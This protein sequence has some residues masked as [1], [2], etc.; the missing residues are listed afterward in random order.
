M[1]TKWHFDV[2]FIATRR[3]QTNWGSLANL[4]L[5]WTKEALVY[6]IFIGHCWPPGAV[7]CGGPTVGKA[8]AYSAQPHGWNSQPCYGSSH[9]FH[10]QPAYK[11]IDRLTSWPAIHWAS[12]TVPLHPNPPLLQPAHDWGIWALV[13]RSSRAGASQSNHLPALT[14]PASPRP[15]HVMTDI[16]IA[17]ITIVA[18]T[19]AWNLIPFH[20]GHLAWELIDIHVS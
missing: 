19:S 8:A 11:A 6:T 13:S 12:L 3:P 14:R 18:E 10:I 1:F 2:C 7:D 17:V 20:S 5:H 4:H 9:Y 16:S 15:A